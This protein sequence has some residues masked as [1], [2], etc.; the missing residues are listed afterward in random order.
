[1]SR[2]AALLGRLCAVLCAAALPLAA[3]DSR[4]WTVK[5]PRAPAPPTVDGR[6]GVEEWSAAALL[7][8]FR[9]VEPVEGAEPTERTEVR[10]MVDADALYVAFRCFDSDAAAIISSQ[11]TRD[12]EI[13]PDDR[14][15][16]VVD[17]FLDRRNAYF[18]QTNPTGAKGDA[19]IINNM[20]SF[21]KSYDT[22]FESRST[23]DAEGWSCEFALPAKSLSFEPA[24]DAFG[25]N[26]M[27]LVKR[28]NE[29]IRWA[30]PTRLAAL[31][32]PVTAGTLEGVGVL[33]PGVGLDVVPHATFRLDR[34]HRARDDDATLDPGVDVRWRITP[35]LTGV[36]TVNTDFADTEVDDAIV[37]LTRFPVFFPEKRDFFLEDAGI[38]TFGG[39]RETTSPFY[40]RRIGLSSAGRPVPLL[41][42]AKLTGRVGDL[43]VGLLDVLQ[44][45]EAGVEGRNLAVARVSA[46]VFEE[47]QVGAIFT[48]GD[49]RTNGDNAVAGVDFSYRTRDFLGDKVLR[50]DAFAVGSE[51]SPDP[52]SGLSD[53]T[54]YFYGL[55]A[56]YPNDVWRLTAGYRE[57]SD[58]FRPDLGFIGRR[59]DRNAFGLFE[60]RP[61]VGGG[62]RRLVF[63]AEPDVHWS[64]ADGDI[65]S[66][67]VE[68]KPAGVEFESEDAAFLFVTP[69]R[70]RLTD[71]FQI[72]D[73]TTLA[74]GV[75]DFVRAGAEIETSDAR[76]L[77]GR[78]R[79]E[80]GS[81]YDGDADGLEA[82]V[83]VRFPPHVRVSLAYERFHADLPAGSFTTNLWRSKLRVDFTPDVS[84]STIAQT[85]DV[86][87]TL[88]VQSRLRYIH[89]PGREAALVFT[90]NWTTEDPLSGR[91]RLYPERTELAL[92]LEYVFRF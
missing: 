15:E 71:P 22:I 31:Y 24:H 11:M 36:L 3:Q 25:F 75:Y 14:V 6:I 18:F 69:T 70:E 4:P 34:D 49:P 59:D 8:D 41:A 76:A 80:T 9:Q 92:K 47:S 56:S 27:R 43:N 46:N 60:F 88:G 23:I 17:T 13:S 16:F 53:E 30:T 19:L 67:E 77:S 82:E 89:A 35:Y 2:A 79:L 84:W 7:T 87:D 48:Y 12:A 81:F 72:A 10:L 65:D 42:G 37:N 1:M 58:D 40:S 74:P 64:L 85:D 50:V 28:K 29:L 26:F 66:A 38:F 45:E 78:L 21:V 52:A 73:A 54:G 55:T 63:S 91:S 68:L 61:R 62:V 83:T 86:S 57:T 33:D 39:L 5:V 32:Q 20:A 51:D 44:D 90:R